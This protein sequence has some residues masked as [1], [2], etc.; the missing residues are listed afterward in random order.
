MFLVEKAE[1]IQFSHFLMKSHH[2]KDSYTK[3]KISFESFFEFLDKGTELRETD[4]K[5]ATLG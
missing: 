5:L 4:W 1:E 2:L 3:V